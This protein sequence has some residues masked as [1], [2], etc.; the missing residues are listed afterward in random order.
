MLNVR[1]NK[2]FVFTYL[3]SSFSL[4][5]NLYNNRV[6]SVA[7]KL[8]RYFVCHKTIYDGFWKRREKLTNMNQKFCFLVFEIKNFSIN[9]SACK[10]SKWAD[11]KYTHAYIEKCCYQKTF[12]QF[13]LLEEVISLFSYINKFGTNFFYKHSARNSVM[14]SSYNSAILST[15]DCSRVNLS[16]FPHSL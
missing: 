15:L 7:P 12:I 4:T 10:T 6:I 16:Q 11:T 3:I 9:S 14:N 8:C 1:R 13:R 5:L 2:V